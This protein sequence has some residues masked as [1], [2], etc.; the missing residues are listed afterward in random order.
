ME[1]GGQVNLSCDCII[2]FRALHLDLDL[3]GKDFFLSIL[4]FFGT[5]WDRK[6]S[7]SSKCC[8]A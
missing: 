4:D 6:S 8:K 5:F 1:A 7:F 3:D 2:V